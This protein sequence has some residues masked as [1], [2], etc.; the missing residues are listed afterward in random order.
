[1]KAMK[2]D[3]TKTLLFFLSVAIL[4]MCTPD[5]R[6]K[7]GNKE[8]K[9]VKGYENA[10]FTAPD[11][12]VK[13]RWASYENPLAEK[14]KGGMTNKGGKGSPAKYIKSGSA[15]TLLLVEGAGIINR[16][17]MTIN[18][19]DQEVLR[20]MVLKIYWDGQDKPAV[21]VPMGDFFGKVLGH[22]L[23]FETALF[24]DPE[25]R[26]YNCF[27]QMPF[28]KGALMVLENETER[29]VLLFYDV[30][31]T[32][33]TA[34]PADM[35]YFHAYWSRENRTTPGVDFQI[36][37]KIEG[38]GRFLGSHLGVVTGEKYRD[39]WFGEGEVKIYLDGDTDFPTLVG[40]G[41][42][43]YIGTAWGQ[44]VFNHQYQGCLIAENN[45][46]WSF[47]RY[48]I[49]DPVFFHNDIN[50]TIQ[51]MGGWSRDKVREI[52]RDGANLILVT[53]GPLKLLEMDNP[54]NIMDDEFPDSWTNFYRAD[55]VCATA[56]FYLD[57][58]T[59]NLPGLVPVD[60]RIEDLLPLEEGQ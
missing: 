30:N 41:T 47:Y 11:E 23:P 13:T 5:G 54:P 28:K 8:S 22:A 48:H 3:L 46:Q 60:K 4:P 32:Q 12:N 37:P 49:P 24:A 34:P 10:M 26:S 52:V 58:P 35:L 55:D 16:F 6:T 45:R 33:L 31:Y 14:G 39:S 1:M 29:D 51:Q 20:G 40:T 42:E 15:D 18:S 7:N 50:V 27:I 38:K 53:S 43:D 59:S 36:L 2:N 17:W 9:T 57:K 56:Y 44:G 25:G 21:E 19:K